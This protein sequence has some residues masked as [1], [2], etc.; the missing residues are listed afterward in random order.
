MGEKKKELLDKIKDAVVKSHAGTCMLMAAIVEDY[1]ERAIRLDLPKLTG[2][3]AKKWFG[4]Y[5]PISSLAAKI[6]FAFVLE[7]IQEEIRDDADT[8]RR[9][10]N[11]FAHT[12]NWVSFQSQEIVEMCKKLSTFKE[13]DTDMQAV[14]ISAVTKVIDEVHAQYASKMDIFAPTTRKT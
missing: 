1:L 10:R 3:L 9:I 13:G 4:T 6:E 7:I 8:I 2:K 11:K 12:A 5:G 14:Y